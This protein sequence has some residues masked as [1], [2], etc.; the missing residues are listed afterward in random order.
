MARRGAS[1]LSMV[2]ALLAAPAGWIVYSALGIDHNLPL[3]PAVDAERR[4]F[5]SSETGL[6]SYYVDRRRTGHPVVLIH[7]I[8]AA[9]SAYEM[10]PLF[11]HYRGSRPV[12]ALDLPGFG[13]SERS[14]REYS[15]GLYTQ[16]ILDF[17]MNEV[18]QPADVIALSLGCEFVAHAA[19]ARPDLFRS[20]TMISPTGFTAR[21]HKESSQWANQRGLSDVLHGMFT[22]PV[23][24]QAF[25]DLLATQSSIRYF[26]GKN[27]EGDV[28]SG[29]AAY[30]YATSHQPGARHAPLYFI[31]GNLFTPN[32]YQTV[33]R[34]L[35]IPVLVIY[36]R[37]PNVR[38]DLLE[39]ILHE[40]EDW[41]AV[42][43]APTMGLPQFEQLGHM[44]RML[45]QFWARQDALADL[46]NS[47]WSALDSK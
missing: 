30:S 15:P 14:A 36:D 11:E 17:L 37:D 43:I 18:G 13:F 24:S 34:R 38:F 19:L 12:Y 39:T 46:T 9:A 1:P 44:T 47:G 41:N 5:L 45:D 26:L 10:R 40:G 29:L 6:V 2:V 32:I 31:S 27:F 25:Y 22:F 7:S 20:L 8:N 42:R 28:D 33:Y 4:V 16:A 21:E 3:E 35:E 23:W